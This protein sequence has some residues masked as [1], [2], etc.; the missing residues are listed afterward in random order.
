MSFE[1]LTRDCPVSM[2]VVG[3]FLALLELYKAK[4]VAKRCSHQVASKE[5][6]E[7]HGHDASPD[8]L[9]VD[10]YLYLPGTSLRGL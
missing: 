1:A 3:R 5:A 4:A 10:G 8:G 6:E 9:R 7:S 2:E